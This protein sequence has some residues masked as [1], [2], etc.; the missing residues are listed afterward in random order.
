VAQHVRVIP[1]HGQHVVEVVRYAASH[2]G[3][4]AQATGAPEREERDEQQGGRARQRDRGEEERAAP[5]RREHRARGLGG[6]HYHR[7]GR[8]RR[9]VLAVDHADLGEHAPVSGGDA[10]RER[11]LGLREP[12]VELAEGLRL[13]RE[14]RE[15]AAPRRAHAERPRAF[16]AAR[17]DDEAFGIADGDG[18]DVR[19]PL[20]DRGQ[21]L[22][23]R[24]AAHS[25]APELA[26]HQLV[27]VERL[28]GLLGHGLRE[29]GEARGAEQREGQRDGE[30][31]K[32]FFLGHADRANPSGVMLRAL[33]GGK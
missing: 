10:E 12:A 16:R 6:R 32:K 2:E 9:A 33:V 15:A 29:I 31:G 17:R 14:L 11:F 21:Q 30:R 3:L 24:G 19:Q 23:Q 22:R 26:E 20:A 1:D 13:H 5:P 27:G 7:T 28:P 25:R 4:L 18:A 8:A